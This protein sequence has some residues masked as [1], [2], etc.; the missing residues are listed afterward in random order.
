M[1]KYITPLL[2][3]ALKVSQTPEEDNQALTLLSTSFGVL[4]NLLCIDPSL[5]KSDISNLIKLLPTLT[6]CLQTLSEP[7]ANDAKLD[8]AANLI[9]VILSILKGYDED[10][11]KSMLER[12]ETLDTSMNGIALCY[13]M[14]G[15]KIPE[16]ITDIWKLSTL[17]TKLI[18]T[19]NLQL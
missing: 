14:L 3:V 8:L 7:P 15:V 5:N 6:P 19:L 12:K 9:A 1:M 11:I 2:Q 17:G 18:I 16:S 10:K 4:L 13:Q